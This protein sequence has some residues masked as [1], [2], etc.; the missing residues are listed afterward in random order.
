MQQQK[1]GCQPSITNMSYCHCL[2]SV[3][4]NYCTLSPKKFHRNTL[5]S[6]PCIV[7]GSMTYNLYTCNALPSTSYAAI[8]L[9]PSSQCI[10]IQLALEAL[11]CC[12][13]KTELDVHM[14]ICTYSH[15]YIRIYGDVFTFWRVKIS[16]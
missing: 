4:F 13:R 16:P 9:V 1:N 15:I 14:Y 11:V 2:R 8:S 3:I 10:H 7:E 12:Q 6:R 5:K